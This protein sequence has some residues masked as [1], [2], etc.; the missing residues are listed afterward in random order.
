[1]YAH[2]GRAGTIPTWRVYRLSDI[3]T[4]KGR[5]FVG[6]LVHE[7]MRETEFVHGKNVWPPSTLCT[8]TMNSS[9]LV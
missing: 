1:M 3:M 8:Q 2:Y 7:H 6:G 9:L 4:M 5:L